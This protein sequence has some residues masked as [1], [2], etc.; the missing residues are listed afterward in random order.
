[1]IIVVEIIAGGLMRDVNLNL[2]KLQTNKGL[3]TNG[4]TGSHLEAA[5]LEAQLA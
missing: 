2:K 1:M 3:P 4:P 5:E